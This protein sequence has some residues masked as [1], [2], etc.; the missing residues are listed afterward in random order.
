MKA[1][2][3]CI[4]PKKTAVRDYEIMAIRKKSV[5]LRKMKS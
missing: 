1:A 2:V 5:R 3:I 4:L